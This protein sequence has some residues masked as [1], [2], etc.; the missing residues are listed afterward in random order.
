MLSVLPRQLKKACERPL[1]AKWARPAGHCLSELSG[2]FVVEVKLLLAGYGL[3]VFGCGME[4]P[5]L[6]GRDDVL[7]DTVAQTAGHLDI[8]NLA[9]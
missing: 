8:G 9:G 6:D 7:V 1:H 5:L 4:G 3:A 2:F